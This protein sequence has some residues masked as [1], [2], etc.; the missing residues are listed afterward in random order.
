MVSSTYGRAP[1]PRKASADRGSVLDAA[2]DHVLRDRAATHG[3]LADNFGRIAAIWSVHLG[4]TVTT[5]Q[6]AILL[7]EMKT[8]RAW[9]NPGH[10]DNWEDLAG[11]AACGGELAARDRGEGDG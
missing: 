2:R 3:D 11:Y 6:V 5:A 10:A 7:A 4:V 9:G 8:V 1:R